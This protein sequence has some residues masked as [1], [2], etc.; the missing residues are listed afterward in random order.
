[1]PDFQSHH[2]QIHKDFTGWNANMPPEEVVNIIARK[3]DPEK[4]GSKHVQ[5]VETF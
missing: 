5:V 2:I 4:E 1:M 3:E